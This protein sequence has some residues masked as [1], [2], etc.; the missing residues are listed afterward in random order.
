M[1]NV[2]NSDRVVVWAIVSLLEKEIVTRKAFCFTSY[3]IVLLS[4]SWSLHANFGKPFPISV[5]SVISYVSIDYRGVGAHVG[6][7][8]AFTVS[9]GF[10]SP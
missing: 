6:L 4:V 5:C 7:Y 2:I 8:S 1:D 9:A 3:F 10:S